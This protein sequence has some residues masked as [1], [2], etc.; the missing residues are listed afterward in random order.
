MSTS[1]SSLEYLDIQPR[2]IEVSNKNNK[3]LKDTDGLTRKQKL[4]VENYQRHGNVYKASIEAGYAPSTAQN[5]HSTILKSP[6]VIKELRRRREEWLANEER[7]T[8]WAK[9]EVAIL[10]G[11]NMADYGYVD[12]KGNWQIDLSRCTREMWACI[13]EVSYDVNGRPKI[14]LI[15]KKAALELHFRVNGGLDNDQ[16]DGEDNQGLDT[17]TIDSIVKKVRQAKSVTINNQYNIVQ[18]QER[19][20]LLE[21][22]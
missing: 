6:A 10:A 18:S 8:D 14:R 9:G 16:T 17:L 3:L 22:K 12:D 5:A 19:Q 21:G 2:L 11:A 20:Q 4:F 15:D 7:T 1:S 13:Q